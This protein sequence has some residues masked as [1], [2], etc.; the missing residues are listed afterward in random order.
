[1]NFK[2]IRDSIFVVAGHTLA[3]C[4]IVMFYEEN[5]TRLLLK[6]NDDT[7]TAFLFLISLNVVK[8]VAFDEDVV[9]S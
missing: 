8:V 1:V 4:I 9:L 5:K 2:G 7:Q 6:L 3:D